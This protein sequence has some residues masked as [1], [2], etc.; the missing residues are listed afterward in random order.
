MKIDIDFSTREGVLQVISFGGDTSLGVDDVVQALRD[1][2]GIRGDLHNTMIRTIARQAAAAP[3]RVIR[4]H[5]PIASDLDL[6]EPEKM[7]FTCLEDVDESLL[8]FA[9]VKKALARRS[10]EEV[11]SSTRRPPGGARS[12]AGDLARHC[13]RG[14]TASRRRCG[15]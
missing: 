15:T 11:L 12:G 5:F 6:G 13:N 9:M 7:V 10:L 14:T 2:Y 4:G 3:H 8:D 1:E